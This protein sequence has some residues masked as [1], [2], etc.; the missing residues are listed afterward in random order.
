MLTRVVPRKPI[1]VS[2]RRWAFLIPLYRRGATPTK[3]DDD[4]Y[5][6]GVP[7]TQRAAAARLYEQ[8][9]GRKLAVAIPN[10]EMRLAI[11]E[12]S[13]VLDKG[14]AALLDGGLVGLAGVQ[15]KDGSLT[16][17]ITAT[18]LF[19]RLGVMRG[20]RAVAI[21]AL[22]ERSAEAGELL[23]D[24]IAVRAD[25]R[26]KRIGTTLLDMVKQFGRDNGYKTVRLDV[27]DTN[28][29][30]RRLYERQGFVAT[31]TESFGYLRWLLGFGAATTMVYTL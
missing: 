29:D 30:A 7:E 4:S 24:G 20:V 31:K 16:S 11:Q 9:F 8:A 10:D 23:M 21:F 6:I 15:T 27:I 12:E 26:G 14:F 2:G 5:Q 22:Y 25:M 13:L 19:R 17:G 3:Q 28:P 18:T 1:F